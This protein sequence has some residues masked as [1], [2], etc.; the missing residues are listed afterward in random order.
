[1]HGETQEALRRVEYSN[2]VE[3][4]VPTMPQEALT[5]GRGQFKEAMVRE[6]H[7]F[8][9]SPVTAERIFLAC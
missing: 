6:V 7:R 5:R 8:A 9:V 1:M 4:K 2:A 3:W